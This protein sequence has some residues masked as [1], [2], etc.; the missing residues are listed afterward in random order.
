MCIVA[1][2]DL[3]PLKFSPVLSKRDQDL[4][5]SIL[6]KRSEEP[7]LKKVTR[8]DVLIKKVIRSARKFYHIKID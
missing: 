2:I 5:A 1:E 4:L 8:N 7:R 6:S 3:E